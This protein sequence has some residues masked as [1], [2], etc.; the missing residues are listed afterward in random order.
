MIAD[1]ADD[2]ISAWMMRLINLSETPKSQGFPPLAATRRTRGFSKGN[3]AKDLKDDGANNL[4]ERFELKDKSC[5][6]YFCYCCVRYVR[7]LQHV[8]GIPFG[9]GA[10]RTST[11]VE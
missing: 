2:R 7:C 10:F 1:A 8:P 9:E 11:E 3:K 6:Y 4:F 5:D